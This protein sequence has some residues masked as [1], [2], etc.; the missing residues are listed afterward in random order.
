MR[1]EMIT[2]ANRKRM[3]EGVAD[4]ERLKDR[5]RNPMEVNK[6]LLLKIIRDNEDTEYGIKYDFKSIHSVEDFQKRSR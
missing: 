2:A 1:N 4:F 3:A 6:E 5:C